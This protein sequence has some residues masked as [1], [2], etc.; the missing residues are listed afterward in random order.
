[1]DAGADPTGSAGGNWTPLGCAVAGATNPALV[2]M[3][4]DRGA[5]PDDRDLYLACFGDDDH[6]S[7]R[8]LLD[9]AR[10]VAESTA[11]AAPISTGDLEG[12]RL[13]LLPRLALEVCGKLGRATLRT[14]PDAQ[15]YRAELMRST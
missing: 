9:R 8:L 6:A 1:M 15:R 5:V 10:N 14:T 12:V 4:L 7:L 13:L 11:L 3:L 2:Q